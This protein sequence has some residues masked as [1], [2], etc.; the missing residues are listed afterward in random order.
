LFVT[1]ELTFQGVLSNIETFSQYIKCWI[2]SLRD[3]VLD[4]LNIIS[5]QRT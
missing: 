1:C 2:M 5:M 3:Y 4:H